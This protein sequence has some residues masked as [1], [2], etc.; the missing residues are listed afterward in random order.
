MIRPEVEALTQTVIDLRRDFHRH[1]ELGFQEFRTSAKVAEFL[2]QCGLETTEGIAVTGV[3]AEIRG[4]HPGPTLM[5]RADMDALPVAE[6]TDLEFASLEAGKM[7]A[8]GHD[9]HTAILLGTARILMDMKPRL[10]GTVKLVFQPA[11]EGPGGADPM[12]QAGVLQGVDYALGLHLWSDLPCGHVAVTPGPVMAAADTFR[13]KIHGKG[14]HAA[15]PHESAD[16]IVAAS[17][18]IMA[19]QT[20][21]SRNTSPFDSAVVS[22]TQ[23]NGGT[24]DNIIPERAEFSG[25]IRTFQPAT[26]AAL[27]ARLEEMVPSLCKS[28]GT[29]GTF[30]FSEGYPALINNPLPCQWVQRAAEEMRLPLSTQAT[31]GG[32]DM[33]YYLQKV[34]GAF[35]F[36]GAA[37]DQPERVFPHHHPKFQL[38]E[39]AVPL[40]MELFLR[41]VE[42][43]LK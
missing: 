18:L 22:V 34:P 2:K 24:A 35:F 30:E 13:V 5:L 31:M 41:C 7:H 3:T 37:P 36:L 23:I 39:R 10:K 29:V 27:L 43:C 17:A 26:K 6:E 1:P 15:Y 20:L 12:I 4:D 42:N 21:V 38:D 11:E 33:A 14:G 8:C 32:E 28:Y 25:T 16:P 40:A 9:L 19:L